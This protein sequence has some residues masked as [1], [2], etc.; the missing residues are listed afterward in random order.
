MKQE[1]KINRLYQNHL[2]VFRKICCE[3]CVEVLSLKY[4]KYV[5]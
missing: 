4:E 1:K 2:T 5:F 3:V